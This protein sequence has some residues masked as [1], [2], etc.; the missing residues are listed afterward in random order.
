MTPV[1]YVIQ[2][3]HGGPV[4]IGYCAQESGVLP[5]LSAIQTGNPYPL[6]VRRIIPAPQGVAL[7]RELHAKL[8]RYRIS[9]EWFMGCPEV[10][11]LTGAKLPKA[12]DEERRLMP[13][14]KATFAAGV[15]E[16]K[17]QSEMRHREQIREFVSLISR[18]FTDDEALLPEENAMEYCI[19]DL[20]KW[21]GAPTAAPTGAD[22]ESL[23]ADVER[24]AA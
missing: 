12:Q 3:E 15:T 18:W 6:V 10:A 13:L 21:L 23:T 7:E 11:M 2:A 4:K 8:A 5:R 9:G 16:G 24:R 14:L 20:R 17:R 22:E 1:V 19:R